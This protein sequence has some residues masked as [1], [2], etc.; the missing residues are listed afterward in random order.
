MLCF[1]IVFGS[2]ILGLG[3]GIYLS[4]QLYNVLE[5]EWDYE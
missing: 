2:A 5:K 4:L 3:L 1:L